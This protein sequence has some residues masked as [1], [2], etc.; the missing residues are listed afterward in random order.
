[1][2]GTKTREDGIV[3]R[4]EAMVNSREGNLSKHSSKFS[5]TLHLQNVSI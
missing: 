4:I 3:K 5:A 2:I 1:M